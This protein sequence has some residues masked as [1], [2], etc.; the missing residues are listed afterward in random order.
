MFKKGF[1]LFVLIGCT[2]L[3]YS[4]YSFLKEEVQKHKDPLELIPIDAAIILESQYARTVW[5]KITETNLVWS[6]LSAIDEIRTIDH[7]IKTIDSL[8]STSTSLENLIHDKK[9]ICSFHPNGDGFDLFSSIVCNTN[10]YEAV[11]SMITNNAESASNGTDP[12]HINQF[13]AD[14]NAYYFTYKSP[15][16]LISSAKSLIETSIHQQNKKESLLTDTLFAQLNNTISQSAPINCFINTSQL[17]R[18]LTSYLTKETAERWQSGDFFPKWI[19]LDL[20]IKSDAFLLTGLGSIDS[21]NSL[22]NS[23]NSQKPTHSQLLN[24][25]PNA[26]KSFQR[27][28]IENPK[29]FIEKNSTAYL[30]KLEANCN[31]DPIETMSSWVGNEFVFVEH[32]LNSETNKPIQ[33]IIVEANGT[34]NVLGRLTSLG[35]QDSIIGNL[36]GSDVFPIEQ[37]DF[38]HLFGNQISL[39]NKLYYSQVQDYAIFSTWEGISK[40]TNQWKKEQTIIQQSDFLLFSEKAMANFSSVDYYSVIPEMLSNIEIFFKPQFAK[41]IK[42]YQSTFENLGGFSWQSSPSN[43]QLQFHSIAFDVKQSKE[44]NS[45]NL[46]SLKLKNKVTRAPEL[47]KN[48]RTNTLEVLI[49]D[50]MNSIHLIGANGKIKWSKNLEGAIMGE[51]K[52]IDV[53]ANNK[54]QMLFNTSEKIHLI[55][56]NGNEVSGFPVVL[57]APATNTVNPLD[58]EKN[59]DYRIFIACSD[60]KIYNYDKTGNP[61][62]GW[63][64][65]GSSSII[66]N[67]IQHFMVEN[68]DYILAYDFNGKIYLLDRKGNEREVIN[69]KINTSLHNLIK[70]QK[71]NSLLTSK[72]SYKDTTGG[73]CEILLSDT[74]N[75]FKLD[76]VKNSNLEISDLDNDNFKEFIISY[77]NRFEIFGA[78]KELIYF[79]TFD[80]SINNNLTII[81]RENGT[82]YILVS[83]DENIYLF[84]HK[85]TL[86]PN[87]PAIGSKLT[88]VGDINKDGNTNVITIKDNNEVIV[89]SIEGLSEL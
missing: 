50:N 69:A 10:E 53:Y 57:K 81:G 12:L 37:N 20:S 56:I 6:E 87:F 62:E 2:V 86:L 29:E 72:I 3:L 9:F 21:K 77:Q 61:V 8:L 79:E 7:S 63:K 4:A 45:K 64:F 74:K 27:F 16:L 51:V 18:G 46:W 42:S 75:C 59:K 80:F 73:I 54:F 23:L 19:E 25:L 78:D 40:I 43:N 76:T 31:C 44:S 26:L 52:Q 65:K 15:F 28:S 49:Q 38:L 1:I 41:K 67:P 35:V 89:Y 58:Y 39:N 60:N 85:F 33:S 17:G 55:D 13:N 32:S 84:N 22:L 34:E 47:M 71:G 83:D 82:K 5:S 36:N 30:E 70:F 48:H 14:G 88:T 24:S 11:K 68:K 66:L